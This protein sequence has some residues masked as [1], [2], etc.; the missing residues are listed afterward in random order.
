MKKLENK[1]IFSEKL[2]ISW[3]EELGSKVTVI[4]VIFEMK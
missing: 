1:V 4:E 3:L 2:L